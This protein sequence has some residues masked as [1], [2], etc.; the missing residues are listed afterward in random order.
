MSDQDQS[1]ANPM[2]RLF[3]FTKSLHRD[4][5][6]TVDPKNPRNSA[7][8][9][10]VLVTGAS[11]GIG[12]GIAL[13]WA[14]AGA[15]TIII[16]GRDEKAMQASVEEVKK[17][18][19]NA[20]VL[21]VRTELTDGKAVAELFAKVKSEVDNLDVL[22]C[23][24]GGKVSFD[25]VKFGQGDPEDWW[26]DMTV[27]VKGTYLTIHHYIATFP[28]PSDT[29]QSTNTIILISS[30]AAL[31]TMPGES[32]YSLAKRSVSS[33][34]AFLDGEYPSL[35]TFALHPGMVYTSEKLPAWFKT[36]ALDTPELAAGT[37]LYLAT[38]RADFLRGGHVQVNWDL[39]EMEPHG[40]EIREKGLLKF[41]LGA[42]LGPEGHQ[43]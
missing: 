42:D 27:N 4:V 3:S 6:P 10:S 2:L 17:A 29:S 25:P 12:K 35:R 33:M 43:F 21:A 22:I 41:K 24:A 8:G 9:K 11:R 16:T 34:P 1:T 32:S 5:Y 15:S 23:N 37:T 28:P 18:G 26:D 36:I 13:A 39:G 14:T 20:K 38:E 19:P 30:G 31:V 40:K 7:A